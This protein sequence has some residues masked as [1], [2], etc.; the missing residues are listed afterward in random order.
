MGSQETTTEPWRPAQGSLRNVLGD[1]DAMRESG[2]LRVDPYGGQRV[3]DQSAATRGGIDQMTGGSAVTQPAQAAYLDSLQNNPYRDFDQ[4]RNTVGDDVQSRLMSSFGGGAMDNG[5]VQQNISRGMAEGLGGL[6]YDAYNQ[7]Q[8][9]QLQT[10]GMAPQLQGMEYSDARNAVAGGQMTDA[11][12]Q[13]NIN[14][15]MQRYYEGEN[16]DLN[17]LR[18]YAGL[19]GP[20]GGMGST[21]TRPFDWAQALMGV[22]SLATG[23]GGL[24]TGLAGMK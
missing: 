6:E 1:A 19:V 10:I 18:E 9:R 5:L 13:Q 11:Y 7:A 24:L 4:I 14:A 20:M 17:A 3:A 12:N 16:V 22:G 23:G 15:D 8:N 2:G 21:T